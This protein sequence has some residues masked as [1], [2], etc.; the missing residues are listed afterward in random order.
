[1]RPNSGR[2]PLAA[3]FRAVRTAGTLLISLG[4]LAA[5][6]TGRAEQI[7]LYQALTLAVTTHPSVAAR[8]SEREA[9]GLRLEAAEWGRYPTLSMQ[10]G[11]DQSGRR[12]TTARA[13][14]PLYTGGQISGQIDGASAGVRGADASVVESQQELM[15]RVVA[16]FVELGRVHARQLAAQSNVAEH[17]RLA[18]LIER[19]VHNQVSPASDGVL[20]QARLAQA[21]AE[22]SQLDAQGA[23]ARAL[24]SQA[25]ARDVTDIVLPGPLRLGYPSLGTATDAAL[26]FSP[27]LRRLTAEEEAAGAEIAVRRAVT[28][29]R[30]VARY[31]R[32]FGDSTL[33]GDQLFVAVEFQSGAGLSSLAAVREAEARRN[34]ARL[35]REAAIRDLT[36]AVG[37]DWADRESLT[38][39]GRDLRAQVESTTEVFDSFV[40]QYAVGRKSWI[41]VLNAQREAAQARYALADAEWGELRATLRLQLASGDLTAATLLS[42]P[43]QAAHDP[44]R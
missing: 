26:G 3:P 37:A 25:I 20:A 36:E 35:G 34:A 38:R 21:R 24:L 15:A 31:D 27:T 16:A 12:Y 6:A 4:L 1:M 42:S 40:R 17:E 30:V 14:Q 5:P 32:T 28:R 19:R 41:D 43:A 11:T 23:R 29:P 8:H 39:Q 10:H 13:E 18:A 33:A 22:A 44:A 9:A 2:R 7:E